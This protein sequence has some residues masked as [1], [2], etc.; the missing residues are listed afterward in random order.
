MLNTITGEVRCDICGMELGNY[1]ENDFYRL[2]RIKYCPQCF[3]L[4]R[5]DQLN[6][7]QRARRKRIRLA[8][9]TQEQNINEL[10]KMTVLLKEQVK[11]LEDKN[12]QLRKERDR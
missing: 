7:A 11:I 4:I 8:N 6:A 3:A 12:A 5:K 2:I 9:K 1:L 10:M